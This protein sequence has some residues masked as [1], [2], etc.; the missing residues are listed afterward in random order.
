MPEVIGFI[1]A[2]E[3]HSISV[4]DV[5]TQM[6]LDSFCE[7]YGHQATIE[8]ENGNFV[9]N[10]ISRTRFVTVKIREFS[11]E[12]IKAWA[13]KNAQKQAVKQAAEAVDAMFNQIE[14]L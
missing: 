5:S 4:P 13:Q 3:T 11:Q 14:Y 12:I 2:G 6:L 9:D 7:T 8:D 10:P 1:L